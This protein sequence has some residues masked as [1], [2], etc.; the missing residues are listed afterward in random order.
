MSIR[1]FTG[2]AKNLDSGG[3]CSAMHGLRANGCIYIKDAK[4]VFH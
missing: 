4:L 1:Y 3:N 2:S